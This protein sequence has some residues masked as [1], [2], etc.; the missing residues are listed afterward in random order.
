MRTEKVPVSPEQYPEVTTYLPLIEF[1]VTVAVNKVLSVP[2]T[3]PKDMSLP[4]ILPDTLPVDMHG[5]LVIEIVPSN[6]VPL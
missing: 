3:T 1:E 5:E 2:A 4:D 6:D